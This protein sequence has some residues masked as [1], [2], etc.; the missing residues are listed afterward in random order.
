MS[1]LDEQKKINAELE[2]EIKLKERAKAIDEDRL[3]LSSGLVDSIKETVGIKSRISTFD[4]NLLIVLKIL[5]NK[6]QKIP[7]L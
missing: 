3:S 2:K 4:N 6:S 1:K 5:L 7:K